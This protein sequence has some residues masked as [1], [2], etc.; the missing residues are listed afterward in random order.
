MAIITEGKGMKVTRNLLQNLLRD[1]SAAGML[2]YALLAALLVLAAYVALHRMDKKI[3]K[4]YNQIGKK[5]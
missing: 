1:D 5:F 2:E 3:A 4:D